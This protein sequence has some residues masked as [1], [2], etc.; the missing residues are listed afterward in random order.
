M[1]HIKEKISVE[2]AALVIFE[3]FF[4]MSPLNQKCH[5]IKFKAYRDMQSFRSFSLNPVNI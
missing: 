4:Y 5:L 2:E 3:I 1:F